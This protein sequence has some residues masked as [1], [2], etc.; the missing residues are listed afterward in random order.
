MVWGKSQK[1]KKV[2]DEAEIK[3]ELKEVKAA[4]QKHF[5]SHRR[6]WSYFL[7]QGVYDTYVGWKTDG[8]SR[9]NAKLAARVFGIKVNI[10]VDPLDVIIKIVTPAG[11][12][13]RRWASALRFAYKA[14]V[15]P[16]DLIKFVKENGGIAGCARR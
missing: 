13:T 6:F 16:K 8:H 4:A 5:D 7:L 2:T 11:V 15:T 14:G 3:R 9:K 12:D 1:A 10:S